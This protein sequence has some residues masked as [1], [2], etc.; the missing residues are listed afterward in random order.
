MKGAAYNSFSDVDESDSQCLPG[1]RVDLL[2][3]VRDWFTNSSKCIFWLNGMAG[4][5]KSTIARTLAAEFDDKKQLGASF[6]FKRGQ[7]DRGRASGFFTTIANQ[8]VQAIPEIRPLISKVIAKDPSVTSQTLQ[9]QFEQLILDP[10]KGIDNPVQSIYLIVIDALDECDNETHITGIVK[11]LSQL[12]NA[13]NMN[14][15]SIITSR[16]EL[17]PKL[18]FQM[19]S[20]YAYRD[21]VLHRIEKN[22]VERDIALFFEHKFKQIRLEWSK[23]SQD[24]LPAQWPGEQNIKTLT[25]SAVPLFIFAATV[26]RFIGYRYGDPQERLVRVLK[27]QDKIGSDQMDKTYKP[28]LDRILDAED[29]GN[30]AQ[31]AL[32]IQNFRDVVG[33]II[34]LA[35]YLSINSLANLLKMH[36][37]DI[38]RQLDHLHSVLDISDDPNRPVRPLH[39]SFPNYLLDTTRRYQHPFWIDETA[40]HKHLAYKCISLLR[41]SKILKQDM[42]NLQRPGFLRSNIKP[43]TVSK[44]IPPSLGYAC[45]YWVQHLQKGQCKINDQDEFHLFLNERFLWWLEA[46]S[47]LGRASTVEQMMST[48]QT[49]VG[50]DSSQLTSFL[51]DAQQFIWVDDSQFDYTPLQLYSSA[52]IFAPQRSVIRN[53]HD[54][55]KWLTQAPPTAETWNSI[56]RK[57]LAYSWNSQTRPAIAETSDSLSHPPTPETWTTLSQ[58]FGWHLARVLSVVF[59]P[60]GKQLASASDDSTIKIWDVITGSLQ[61]TLKGHTQWVGSTVFSADGKQLASSSGDGTIKI[62]N[63]ATGSLHQTIGAQDVV[64]EASIRPMLARLTMN[65]GQIDIDHQSVHGTSDS[66]GANY[67][68][69]LSGNWIM[70]GNEHILRLPF[71][72]RSRVYTS[73]DQTIALG[74]DRGQV[75][76]FEFSFEGTEMSKTT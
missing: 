18:G 34:I 14:V 9:R 64:L 11:L 33:P 54:S 2:D 51:Q 20:K 15:K 67:N 12:Q 35:D 27:Y 55:P 53:K 68:L 17:P 71:R 19:I 42:C 29:Q 10:L 60:D 72:H 44:R 69:W 26:C 39:L 66:L 36:T 28:I 74:S 22:I 56:S 41:G 13:G 65:I 62:W 59:S 75:M 37:W 32:V 30:G 8:L 40:M 7:G 45:C 25:A 57:V 47:L 76:F 50:K 49:L 21:L 43:G 61:Y 5:G 70:N 73:M 58:R 24:D 63:V 46:M 6:F 16:P 4:T 48:L 31:Q 23:A 3:K 38:S 1:T 52:L